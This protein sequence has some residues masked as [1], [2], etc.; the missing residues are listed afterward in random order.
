MISPFY[1]VPNI[2]FIALNTRFLNGFV[3][4]PTWKLIDT[5]KFKLENQTQADTS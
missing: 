5:F 1:R 4:A 2:T 3:F